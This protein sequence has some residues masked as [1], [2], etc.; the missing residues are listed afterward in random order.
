M[1]YTK[2]AWNDKSV[3]FHCMPNKFLFALLSRSAGR[4]AQRYKKWSFSGIF[5]RFGSFFLSFCVGEEVRYIDI[6]WKKRVLICFVILV[7]RRA[8]TYE[9]CSIIS[10]FRYL[11]LFPQVFGQVKTWR[12]LKLHEIMGMSHI[13]ACQIIFILFYH[14]GQ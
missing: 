12:M 5:S 2:V 6:A 13:V 3:K 7:G 9:K 14:R 11:G 10:I 8:Q 1:V 4:S